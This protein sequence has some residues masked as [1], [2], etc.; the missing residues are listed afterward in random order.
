ME[1]IVSQ[2]VSQMKT[3]AFQK[4]VG[5]EASFLS[6]EAYWAIQNLT[7]CIV[8]E[9]MLER[10]VSQNFSWLYLAFGGCELNK[11]LMTIMRNDYIL[12]IWG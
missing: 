4:E 7:T 8:V 5:D 6:L 9:S 1:R 11:N 3:V 2:I 10:E 12:R